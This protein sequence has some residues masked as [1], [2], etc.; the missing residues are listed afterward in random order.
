MTLP[1]VTLPSLRVSSSC[2]RVC[3]FQMT[4]LC[5]ATLLSSVPMTLS[6]DTSVRGTL[7]TTQ[8]VSCHRRYCVSSPRRYFC[9]YVHLSLHHATESPDASVPLVHFSPQSLDATVFCCAAAACASVSGG[10]EGCGCMAQP[11]AT[12]PHGARAEPQAFLPLLTARRIFWP[13]H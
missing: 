10:W 3:V 6:G 4:L 13:P 8:S 7:Q 9:M 2:V 11:P 1:C 5:L 12:E